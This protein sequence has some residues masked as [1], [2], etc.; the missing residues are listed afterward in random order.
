MKE[1]IREF[2]KEYRSLRKEIRKLRMMLEKAEDEG[3]SGV[4]LLSHIMSK[5]ARGEELSEY[6]R[7]VMSA[8]QDAI[9]EQVDESDY[10]TVLSEIMSK[11]SEG[12]SLTPEE[13]RILGAAI[14][15]A[16]SVSE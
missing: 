5:V 13:R 7:R 2:V 14:S 9:R 4:D 11:V 10:I 16:K 6:E 15:A 12:K 8:V 3:W 1:K